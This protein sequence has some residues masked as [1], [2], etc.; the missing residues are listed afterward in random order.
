VTP[1]LEREDDPKVLRQAAQILERENNRLVSRV[2]ELTREN[3]ALKG[4]DASA[5]QAALFDLEKALK[6]AGQP[7]AGTSE[8]RGGDADGEENR[9][10][11]PRDKTGRTGQPALP[12]VVVPNELPTDEQICDVCKSGLSVWEGQADRSEEI[13]VIARSYEIRQSVH[14]KYRCPNGCCV[15]TAPAPLKLVPGGRYSVDFAIEIAAD[16]YL[17]TLPLERQ[18][19]RMAREGLV[20]ESQ[21]LWDQIDALAKLHGPLHERI[22]GYILGKLVIGGDETR[23]RIMGKDGRPDGGS[24]W[25]QMW[26]ACADDSVYFTI[27]DN[28]SSRAAEALLGDFAGTLMCDGYT[29]YSAF[30]KRGAKY[31]LAHCW[32]HARRELLQ[33]EASFPTLSKPGIDLIGELFAIDREHGDDIEKLRE[34]RT[35]RS[36]A[37][38]DKLQEWMLA[39]YTLTPPGSALRD[40][41]EYIAKLWKG[42]TRF[43]G[44][45][46]VPLTNNH[47]ERALR[48]P[49]VGRKNFYG[50]RSRR[51]TEVAAI[52]YTLL[53][54]AKLAG[55]DP[56]AYLRGATYAALR[57]ETPMLPHEAAAAARARA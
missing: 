43:L 45:P 28:R 32:A 25:W 29:A 12:I 15:K 57:G 42:L 36:R 54:S 18:A 7:P 5:L 40:A 51:G 16:K 11:K 3:L 23:W 34:A 10:K 48:G 56:K 38:I 4:L 31:R 20:V 17:D 13:H 41:L 55:V 27:A 6:K 19:R 53:E 46:L 9:P 2:V 22:R 21:T 1:R 47:S 52:L 8:K 50:S 24:K 33:A 37:V 30:Q 26:T 35:K 44:D 49:V 14:F 39:T